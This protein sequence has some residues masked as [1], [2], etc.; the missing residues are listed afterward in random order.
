MTSASLSISSTGVSAGDSGAGT[1]GAVASLTAPTP[2]RI[3]PWSTAILA[4]SPVT[5]VS[6][7]SC[8]RTGQTLTGFLNLSMDPNYP[9]FLMPAARFR[10]SQLYVTQSSL[11]VQCK[12]LLCRIPLLLG[13]LMLSGFAHHFPCS[14]SPWE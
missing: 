4:T 12:T 8:G 9:D 3:A 10:P 13:I 2:P 7:E 6:P 14:P 11:P 5:L 1:A